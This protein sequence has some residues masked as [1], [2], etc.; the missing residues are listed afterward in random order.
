M[1]FNSRLLI[2][3]SILTFLL[4]IL[5]SR[6]TADDDI[7][8]AAPA[9]ASTSCNNPYRLVL[10]KLWIDGA[11]HESIGGLSAA[12]GSL[13]A[14]DNKNTPRLPATYTKPLNACSSSSSKLSGSIALALRG[15]CDFLTK[16]T[17]AQAGGAAGIVLINDEEDL[18]EIGCPDNSSAS[19]ITI[20]VVTISKAGGDVIDK[21]ISA[22]KKV[23]I[24]LYSPDRPILDYSAMFIWLMAV[25]TIFC[26]SFWS[27][28][29]T[30]KES[31]YYEQAPEVNTGV[32]REEDDKEILNITTK[33][34]FVFV[35]SAS[36]FLLLL[37]F[38]MSSWFVWLLIILFAIGGVEGMH[39][40]IISLVLSKCKGCGR[41]T[42]N[43]PLLGE[44]SILSLVVL[45]FCVAFAVFWAATRKASYSWI[46]QDIL[47]IC[48]M[49]TVLQLAQLPNIKVAT[50]LLCCAFLYDIFWVFLSPAIFH[51]SVMIAV[52]RGD[53]AGGESIPML[54]RVPRVTD[55]YGGYDMIGFGDILFP[56]LLV[57]FAFRFDKARSKSVLNGYYIWMM[58][59]YGIGLLFTF[60]ALYLMNGH[61]Q[62]ALLYLVPCTL[63][64]YVVL[65]L[66]RGE[67]KDLWNYDSE[68]TKVADSLLEDA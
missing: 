68:S 58:V 18:L 20:P 19:A 23:E 60:L 67:F 40:C 36:T 7:S 61:G 28:F 37:Y 3:L 33:S 38:F 62:P 66:L 1:A 12:F 32:A 6:A 29:T 21:Y 65:G 8:R 50:V 16:A 35:I 43:L 9:N 51:D 31:N 17:V 55:P 57:C 11:E 34:A 14:G 10:V 48:L 26:A 22:G 27:E 13:L 2:R 4:L 46:G 52:A 54:L 15:Q 30:S 45:I 49:I 39:S 47:G 24:L 44:I 42:L 25:G 41:K 64:T 63:G 56:G 59:G 5:S 53:K